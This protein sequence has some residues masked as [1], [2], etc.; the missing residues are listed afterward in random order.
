MV[1]LQIKRR[2]C[3]IPNLIH[4]PFFIVFN[5]KPDQFLVH[6]VTAVK[7]NWLDPYASTL[8]SLSH[9]RRAAVRSGT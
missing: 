9:Q 6:C 3:H 1:R 7:G 8:D 2:A 5:I 4:K